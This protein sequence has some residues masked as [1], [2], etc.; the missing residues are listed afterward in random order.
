MELKT[1]LQIVYLFLNK[2]T[3]WVNGIWKKISLKDILFTHPNEY[4]LYLPLFYPY[5]LSFCFLLLSCQIIIINKSLN[6]ENLL[7]FLRS[8]L[9]KSVN[10]KNLLKV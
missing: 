1:H 5:D 10:N 3:S 4:F 9:N 6:N 7:E 8:S 2:D